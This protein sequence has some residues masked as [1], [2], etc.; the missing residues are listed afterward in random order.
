MLIKAK[1]FIANCRNV[2]VNPIIFYPNCQH[3]AITYLLCF[4]KKYF[5]LI[6]ALVLGCTTARQQTS[7]AAASQNLTVD[8][9]LFA[10]LF[11]QRA[12][13]YKAL[14]FQAFNIAHIRVD[15]ALVQPQSKPLAIVTDID[16][17]VLD[18]SAYDVKQ[19]LQGK[20]YEQKSWEEWTGLA[21]A[22]TVPGALPFLKYASSKGIKIFYLTNRAEAERKGTLANLVRFG[23]PDAVDENLILKQTV[24]SKES[25]RQAIAEKYNVFMLMGDNLADFSALFDKKPA[26]ERLKNT[27]TSAAEF[28]KRFIVLPNPVYGDWEASVYQY[29]I[30]LKA[31]E[32]DSVIKSVLKS[33]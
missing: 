4:M 22:D 15:E 19:S 29:N 33:Y 11:Q 31:A 12:A 17:T 14:C 6:T 5:I 27:Y 25:R 2:V 26:D 1:N 9:K 10:A 18:N 21:K 13:E 8:G 7:N 24:S 23:F 20:D 3:S 28:G 16:E 30:K 32:K